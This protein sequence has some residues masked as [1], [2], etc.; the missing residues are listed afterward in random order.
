MKKGTLI[1]IGI[2]L[3]VLFIL[4]RVFAGSYNNMVEK[5]ETVV[6]NLY[7]KQAVTMFRFF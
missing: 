3:V 4:Y 5:N 2:I 6:L 1:T 7:S